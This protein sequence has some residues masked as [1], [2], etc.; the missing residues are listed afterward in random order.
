MDMDLA[1]LL[2]KNLRARRGDMTQEV[3]ARKLGISRATL[4][5]LESA[6][7]N[8]TINTLSQI[9]KALKCDVGDLFKKI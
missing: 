9:T 5:R 2:A 6:S 8:T 1:Q 3:F 4:T 7:Q